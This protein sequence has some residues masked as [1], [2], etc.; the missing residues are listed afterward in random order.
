MK[1]NVYG[2]NSRVNITDDP[3]INLFKAYQVAYNGEFVR[4]IKT[5]IDQYDDSYNLSTDKIMTSALNKFYIARKGNK[6]NFMPPEQEHIISLASVVEKLK[7]DN[8]K[9]SNNFKSSTPGKGKGKF[10]GKV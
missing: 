2:L 1:V 5:K 6:W 9:L 7:D 4:Y 8:L 3:I 10:K